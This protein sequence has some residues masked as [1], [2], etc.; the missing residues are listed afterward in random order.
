MQVQETVADPASTVT[1]TSWG[2]KTATWLSHA[3]LWLF[4]HIVLRAL[5]GLLLGFF[6]SLLPFALA[7]TYWV[8][9]NAVTDYL[10]R[11]IIFVTCYTTTA[12]LAICKGWIAVV[13]FALEGSPC[14]VVSSHKLHTKTEQGHR[15]LQQVSGAALFYLLNTRNRTLSDSTA[16]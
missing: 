4:R 9:K 3:S 1:H 11:S 7:L 10:P 12:S 6:H 13:G 16:V 8:S 2:S 15:M 5:A 14:A